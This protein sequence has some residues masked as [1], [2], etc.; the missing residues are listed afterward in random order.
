MD[1]QNEPNEELMRFFK[2]FVD[3]ERLKLVGVLSR[4]QATMQGLVVHTTMPGSEVVRHL[5]QLRE[6]GFVRQFRRPDG[7]DV[8]ELQPQRLEALAKRQ[9]TRAREL[10]PQLAD[11]RQFPA[12]FTEEERKIVMNFTHPSGEIK[13][14]PLQPKK[15]QIIVRYARH[16]VLNALQPGK[17]YTE[18]EINLAIKPLHADAAFFRRTFVDTGYLDRHNNGSAYWLTEKAKETCHAG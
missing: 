11:Q 18:K 17:Q 5:D 16:F 8:F 3:I 9:F 13:Q 14:I 4:G 7:V 1:E 6:S 10:V 12:D 15:Q 2:T